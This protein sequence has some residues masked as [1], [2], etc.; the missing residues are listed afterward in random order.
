MD[1][2]GVFLGGRYAVTGACSMASDSGNSVTTV[3][4]ATI[5]PNTADYKYPNPK[6]MHLSRCRR[7]SSLWTQQM[8][9]AV[10]RRNGDYHSKHKEQRY[11]LNWTQVPRSMFCQEKKILQNLLLSIPV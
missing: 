1:A 11:L 3:R 2:E 9:A 4:S 10:V 6:C 7:R 8:Q 5:L